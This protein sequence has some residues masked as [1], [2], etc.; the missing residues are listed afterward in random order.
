MQFCGDL[1]LFIYLADTTLATSRATTEYNRSAT[2]LKQRKTPTSGHRS[3]TH[4]PPSCVPLLGV[5]CLFILHQLLRLS[6]QNPNREHIE[7]AFIQL[8]EYGFIPEE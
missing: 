2:K 1:P 4:S 6:L 5:T 8:S 7:A 3:S